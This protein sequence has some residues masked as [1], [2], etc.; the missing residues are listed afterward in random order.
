MF[1]FTSQSSQRLA[2]PV[3]GLVTTLATVAVAALALAAPD[4]EAARDPQPAVVTS[5][6]IVVIEVG[7]CK[8]CPLLR[9]D[10]ADGYARS[11]RAREVPIRFVDV[12]A[13]G[14]DRLKLKAPIATVPTA[15]LLRNHVEIGRIEGYVSPEDFT[16]LL[17][18]L[19][20]R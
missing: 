5:M 3:L 10:V 11:P 8:Y 13:Q 2:R 16:R 4:A 7:G 12:T 20:R 17:T 19:L 14:A 6:E 18:D 1:Q 9:Q 15:V